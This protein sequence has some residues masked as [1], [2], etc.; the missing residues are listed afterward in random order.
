MAARLAYLDNLRVALAALVV[1]HHVGQAY[2]PTG[3]AWPIFNPTRAAILGPFFSVNASFFM[4]LFF[5]ISGYCLPRAYDQ[6]GAHAFLRDRMLRLGVPLLVVS[7]G[8]FL[9]LRYTLD[10][11]G[12]PFLPFL[13]GYLRQ[14]EV[15]HMWFVGHLLIYAVA[16][17]LWR[18]F[19]GRVARATPPSAPP[20]HVALLA[21]TLALAAVTFL[22]RIA[23][24]IDR[25]VNLAPFVRA[26]VA[27]LPQYVSLFVLGI[28]AE[29]HDWLRQLPS[30][31]GM[32][33]LVIGLGA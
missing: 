19:R 16:Y 22:V 29:R 4:G 25:W 1:A 8:L 28:V 6:K 18:S 15:G 17:T 2:G 11:H 7:L 21:Y 32:T 10:G 24:P 31:T 5:L 20:S 14:P 33:W 27:H 30:R 9:P 12:Q 3:G 13:A 23:F 26:E